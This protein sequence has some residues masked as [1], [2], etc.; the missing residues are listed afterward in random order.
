[1]RIALQKFRAKAQRAQSFCLYFAP[2]APLRENIFRLLENR[3]KNITI[4]FSQKLNCQSALE[5]KV[6]SRN[7]DG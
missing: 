2:F 4:E 5:L 6:F 7:S 3:S 1:L